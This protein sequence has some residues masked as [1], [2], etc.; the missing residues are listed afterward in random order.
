MRALARRLTTPPRRSLELQREAIGLGLK[1]G[2][3]PTEHVEHASRLVD[4]RR[5]E[6]S[7]RWLAGQRALLER[8]VRLGATLTIPGEP[9]PVDLA[10]FFGDTE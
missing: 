4:A 7:R 8:E 6:A 9:E 1:R 2:V 10:L 5:G 3:Q